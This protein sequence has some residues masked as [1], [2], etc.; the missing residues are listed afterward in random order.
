VSKRT[1][2][3]DPSLF[4]LPDD[5]PGTPPPPPGRPPANSGGSSGGD[6]AVPLHDAARARYLNYALS[7]I[8]ARALPDVRD[9]LKPVQRRILYSMWQQG[10]RADAKHRKSA[11]V[12]GNVLGN[13]HPHGDAS[14]YDALVRMA[15]P[16]SLRYPLVD[17]SGN[18]GS[19]DGDLAAAY[20]YT[21][22]RLA[23]LADQLLIELDQDTVAMRPN[24]DGTKAEP[25][26][27]PARIPNLLINGATG[28]AVGM[29]TNIPPHNLSEVCTALVKLLDNE[30]LT[31]TQLCRWVKGP[32]FPTGGVILNT[33]DELK[34]IY[35]TGSGAVKLRATWELGP[36]SRGS[37]IVYVTSI[38]YALDKTT[39]VERIAEVIEGGRKLPPLLD[40]RDI[41]TDD[42]RIELE[43]KK[44]ADEKMVM[45][46]LFKHTPL[47]TNFNVNLTCLIP[48]EQAEVGRPERLDLK[49]MLWHFLHFRL[50]VVTRRLEHELTALSR[51]Q[52]LLEG[53]AKVFDA[54]DEILRIVRKSEGKADAAK[55]IMARFGLDADQTDAIL[56]LKIY[57]LARLE[58]Q[59]IQE[60]LAAA[61][62]R[63]RE[64]RAALGDDQARWA[65]VR[66]EIEAV[67]TADPS[68]GK[69]ARR[70][71]FA[72][73]EAEVE[74]TAEDFIVDEDGIVI[75]SRDG[76]IKRQ[77]DVKD[78]TATRLRE[79][80][81]VMA[82]MA[83]ST[84]AT[85]VFF[86]NYGT[87][88]T[89]RFIDVP[90]S[91]G[92]GEP[93]QRLFKFKDGER[94]VAAFSLDPRLAGTITAASP[95]DPPP[96]HAVAV[97]SDGYSLRFS[98][99][100]FVE[101]STRAGRRF[102]R[103][104]DGAEVVGVARTTGEETLIAATR[105]AR[106][107]LCRA[108]EVNF[109]SGPGRGVILIKIDPDEDRVL[110][111]IASRGERDL[112]L[113]ETSRGAEQ[114]ISTAKYEVTGRGGRGRELLQRGSF[115]KVVYGLPEVPILPE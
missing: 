106:A 102:A 4:D 96:V 70:T 11:T 82:A 75:L 21:E 51:R 55:Q 71:T 1:T 85:A 20:R 53:F 91:T 98:L 5:A 8:T 60:E 68:I 13:F 101:P 14:V 17:G 33:P 108:D 10:L 32:D 43:L 89:A 92:Y 86:T 73:G 93:I 46:Y 38:P 67:R 54:L 48:T 79:G 34:E 36:S 110:G 41:S 104:A 69:D 7:V 105:E 113:V 107:M 39:V 72:A 66:E 81:A 77:K 6:D 74:Y 58:I 115:A 61:R 28:I 16:F 42:V 3:D 112:L 26:V 22:C 18:F 59:V 95:E 62:K 64:L 24:F 27:L 97:T 88:Y 29:A 57:R 94:V 15:Q 90:A 65:I 56:E 76:W 83:G 103:T 109:L 31:S 80:D 35:R 114:T 100:P 44:D 78:L 37:K 40:V 9:G 84:R 52:H 50:E 30:E 99:A 25:V 111:F 23:R 49:A 12:V 87:A 19:L 45:A 2:S 63:S 47:Q